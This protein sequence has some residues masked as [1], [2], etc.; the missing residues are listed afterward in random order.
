MEKQ[1]RNKYTEAK[2]KKLKYFIYKSH[3][4]RN[5]LAKFIY[6]KIYIKIEKILNLLDH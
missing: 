5:N 1:K 4:K 2:T 3:Y 6:F